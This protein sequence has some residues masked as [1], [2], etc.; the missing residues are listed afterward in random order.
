MAGIGKLI[1]VSAALAAGMPATAQDTGDRPSDVV[2]W[3]ALADQIRDTGTAFL[4]SSHSSDPVTRAE[5]IR[6][7]ARQ[8]AIAIDTMMSEAEPQ[9]TLRL[10]ISDIRKTGLDAAEA[11]Y[12]DAAIDPKGTYRLWGKLG[13]ARHIAI[14]LYGMPVAGASLNQLDLQPKADG[15]FEAMIAA[16][17]PAGWSGPWLKIAPNDNKLYIRE[18]F[19]DWEKEQPSEFYI[20]RVGSQPQA[21]PLDQ[22]R[23]NTLIASIGDEFH[24]RL[25]VWIEKT[26]AIRARGENHLDPPLPASSTMGLQDN[27]Y[28]FGWFTLKPDEALIIEMDPP[29][30]R[31]WS[32]ELGNYW[33]ESFDFVNHTSSLTRKQTL[34]SADGRYR[35]V[36][37][38][39]D[40]GIANW[41]DTAG[42]AEGVILYRFILGEGDLPVPTMRKV[43]FR[44]LSALSAADFPRITPDR[45]EAEIRMRR[46]HAARRWAP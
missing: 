43:P 5:G 16:E 18:Y 44:S 4:S 8:L 7:L 14:Q 26:E 27:R 11:K 17:R 32:F 31:L 6:Y 30:A 23:A 10:T 37:S 1:V 29:K 35:I 21:I 39:N 40:P 24:S 25:P 9:P 22:A 3:E 19:D 34:P 20:A 33:W 38:L 46:Q 41:L 36:V 12:T 13:T 45:R 42:H 2:A 15:S 28:G